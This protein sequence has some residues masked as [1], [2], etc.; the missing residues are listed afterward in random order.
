MSG[1]VTRKLHKRK[2]QVVEDFESFGVI[3]PK[4]FIT[5]GAS[6]PRVLWW[7]LD[8]ATE[9]FEAAIVH[10][11]LLQ[12]ND[13]QAHEEFY[14]QLRKYSVALYK[15]YPAFLAVKTFHFIKSLFK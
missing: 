5:D 9:A 14:R 12:I 7:F 10:D 3:V 2:W 13:K 1:V 8:P 15:A 11:Y 4:D 6:V